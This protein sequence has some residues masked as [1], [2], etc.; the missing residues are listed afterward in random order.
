MLWKWLAKK[1]FKN[2]DWKF[3]T[4]C[5]REIFEK[6]QEELVKQNSESAKCQPPNIPDLNILDLVFFNAIW[7]CNIRRSLKILMTCIIR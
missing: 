6:L 1:K 3:F 2:D 7:H 4:I 5:T